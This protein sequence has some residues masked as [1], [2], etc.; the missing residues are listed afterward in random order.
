MT[1]RRPTE[2]TLNHMTRLATNEVAQT[3]RADYDASQLRMQALG[4]M[5]KKIS[6]EVKQP[7]PG[8]GTALLAGTSNQQD[9]SRKFEVGPNMEAGSP[10]E[11]ECLTY[12]TCYG[13]NTIDAFAPLA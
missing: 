4:Q 11:A 3:L 10:S 1:Q 7:I 2:A 9:S 5:G 12:R 6:E 13:G 8:K